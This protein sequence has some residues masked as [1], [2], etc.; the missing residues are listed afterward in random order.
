MNLRNT[1]L[2][3]MDDILR[4]ENI[5]F[6]YR[7]RKILN[8]ISFSVKPG[9]I[10]GLLG[11]NGCGKTT[12]FKCINGVLEQR[13][14]SIEINGRDIMR[15]SRE[16]LARLIAVVP[17]ELNIVFGFSV[18]QIVLMGGTGR[19][20][21]TGIP[22]QGDHVQAMEILSELGIESLAG[23]RYNEL[24]G[25]EKQMVLIARAL[26]QRTDILLLDEPT[27][28][29]D[30]KRQHAI[31]DMIKKITLEKNLTTIITLHDPNIAGRYCDRLVMLSRGEIR[32]EGPRRSVFHAE[33]L[34][35]IYDMKIR[36][37]CTDGGTECVFPA[38]EE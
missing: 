15:L 16:K 27:S 25:G 34:G 3:D 13:G 9:E 32:Y 24:S 20:G 35:T 33:S 30:F 37:E 26:F 14:G 31:M 38:D 11:P 17:Q 2:P 7:Q 36:I 12:L 28:H 21:F 10:C 5:S 4:V 8:N 22:R 18:L 6:G 1:A 23:R 29:L 19:F